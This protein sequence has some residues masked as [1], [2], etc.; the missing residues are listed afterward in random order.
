MKL[1]DKMNCG[2]IYAVKM[3]IK[4]DHYDSIASFMSKY[5]DTPINCYTHSILETI[6]SRAVAE[7]LDNLE[8]PSSFWFEYWH[9][10]QSPWNRTDFGAICAAMSTIQIKKDGKYI[11]GFRPFEEFDL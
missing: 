7:L 10:K 8:Y 2:V 1:M 11:N 9:F 3:N 4:G 5:T 6:L